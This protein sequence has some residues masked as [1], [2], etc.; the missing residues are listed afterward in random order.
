MEEAVKEQE[1]VIFEVPLQKLRFDADVSGMFARV[2]CDQ[3]FTNKGKEPVEAIYT[4]PLPEDAAVAGCTMVIGDK[5]IDA[6]LKEKVQAKQEYQ[7]AIDA[8]HYGS[9]LEQKRDNIFTISVGGIGPGEDIKISTIYTQRIPWQDNGGRFSIPTVV[10]PRFIPGKPI[11]ET[12]TGGGWSED[13]DEVPDASQITPIVLREGVDYTVD[14]KVSMSPGFRCVLTSPSHELLVGETRY[15]KN[16][17]EISVKD[18]T[19]DRDFIICYK[20]KAGQVEAGVHKGSFDGEGFATIDVVPP[21]TIESK[22]KDIVFLLDVSGSMDSA[23][24]DGLKVVAEK[25]ARKLQREN[26]GNRI[27]VIAFESEIHIMTPLALITDATFDAIHR[28]T[29]QGGTQAGRA[30]DHCFQLLSGESA[31]E[32]YILLVSDG[33]TEDRWSQIIPGIRVISV[34]IDT[35]VNAGYLKDIAR[36]TG[37]TSLAV[38][39]G[40]DYDTVASALVGRLSGP[41]MTDIQITEGNTPLADVLGATE[42]YM[43]MPT[44]LTLKTEKLP[45]TLQLQGVDSKG[46]TV[47]LPLDLASAGECTFAHQ[48]WAREKLR[49]K[50]LESA[51]LVNLSTKY[52]VLCSLTAFVAVHLKEEPGKKPQRVEIPVALPHTWDYEKVFG[53]QVLAASG[54]TGLGGGM[55]MKSM[56]TFATSSPIPRCSDVPISGFLG[57]DT[58]QSTS[59]ASSTSGYRPPES[60]PTGV[61]IHLVEELEHLVEELEAGT[62]DRSVQAATWNTLS[63]K[64]TKAEIESWSGVQ[65]AKGL[66]LLLKLRT[67][68]FKATQEITT[69]LSVEPAQS[70]G[71]A[72]EWWVKAQ[73]LLGVKVTV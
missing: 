1:Q 30:L 59:S 37:G 33:Q 48:I 15:V 73:Q 38:Y 72:H 25:A 43:S 64:L 40:E 35:A 60:Y 42:V 47:K 55:G 26:A 41:V 19:P 29:I 16:P 24:L 10:A 18:L 58:S 14:I 65:R 13:T 20:T 9:L 61:P 7:D 53:E 71:A 12:K 52:G 34:G 11:G 46:K 44:T 68:G 36:E 17:V 51:Q 21:G 54:S 67:F 45:K 5:K 39:P 57:K 49:E 63:Q 8:G 70:D 6:E 31:P 23:K 22:A 27:S 50:G 69:L 56:Q 62:V 4:F 32:K 2:T 3:E 66:Y 28:L